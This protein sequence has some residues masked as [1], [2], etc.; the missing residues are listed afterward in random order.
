MGENW[1]CS[2]AHS[3]NFISTSITGLV[4]EDQNYNT[5]YRE[6]G[7]FSS[8][9][10]LLS[11]ERDNTNFT[12]KGWEKTQLTENVFVTSTN[13]QIVTYIIASSLCL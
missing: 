2:V 1:Q 12:S 6:A 3:K 5:F 10:T 9:G 11:F 13:D 4:C 7:Q 8:D